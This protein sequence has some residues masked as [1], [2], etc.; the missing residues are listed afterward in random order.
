MVLRCPSQRK[1]TK[2]HP[3]WAQLGR[4]WAV[5]PPVLTDQY[6]LTCR[7]YSSTAAESLRRH[8]SSK[9]SES[10]ILHL[11]CG[12]TRGVPCSMGS[13]PVV[14]DNRDFHELD[15]TPAFG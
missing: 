13:N 8:C 15:R 14:L 1:V 11:S 9:P 7:P 6:V 12:N 2:H 5:G 4:N 3:I 10:K